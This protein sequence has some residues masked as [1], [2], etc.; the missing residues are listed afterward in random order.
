MSNTAFDFYQNKQSTN[1]NSRVKSL[2][3]SSMN[4]SSEQSSYRRNQ[5]ERNREQNQRSRSPQSQR[6]PQSQMRTNNYSQSS[7]KINLDSLLWN[8]FLN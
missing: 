3:S 8:E 7:N 1:T 6:T 4:G 2:V 5:N